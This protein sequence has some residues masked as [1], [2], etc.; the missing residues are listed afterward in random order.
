MKRIAILGAG[1]MG[2]ALALLFARK[3]HEVQLWAR[4]RARAEEMAQTRRNLR[5]LPNAEIPPEIVITP[6]ACD[7]SACADLLVAAVPSAFLRATFADLRERV[8]VG[9]PVLSVIK[10]IENETLAR[11]SQILVESLGPRPVAVLSGPSHA[12]ELALG[13]P[14]WSWWPVPIPASTWRCATP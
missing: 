9:V 5:H 12:E 13:M 1:G 8:P 2:T 7:A 10:G 4:D 6:N 11:P 3:G 14:A